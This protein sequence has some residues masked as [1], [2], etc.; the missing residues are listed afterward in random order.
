MLKK[1]ASKKM[2]KGMKL[3][4]KERHITRNEAKED[5]FKHQGNVQLEY[6][7]GWQKFLPLRKGTKWT[8]ADQ[9]ERGFS[10]KLWKISARMMCEVYL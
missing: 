8:K 1:K 6:W 3:C 10:L 5:D 4:Q 7:A 2:R 9:I